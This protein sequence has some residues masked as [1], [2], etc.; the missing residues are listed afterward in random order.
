MSK[1]RSFVVDVN[2]LDRLSENVKIV[3]RL[4]V[5]IPLVFVG[6]MCNLLIVVVLGRDK[7]INKT[8]RFLLQM[9]AL[10]DITYYVLYPVENFLATGLINYSG[11]MSVV[12]SLIHGSQSIASWMAVLVTYQRYVAVSR[13]LHARQYITTS[14]VRIAVVVIWIG[15]LIICTPLYYV[16]YYG[17][18]F[19]YLSNI[20]Q[21]IT[22]YLLPISLTVFLNI[23]LIV[24]IRRSRTFVGQQL[25]SGAAGGNIDSHSASSNRVTVT[26]IVILI[27]Y[28]VCQ[29]PTAT[30][31]VLFTIVDLILDWSC[32]HPRSL[33]HLSI[34]YDIS[35]CLIVV[36]SL[37]DCV[38]YCMIGKRFRQILLRELLC[39]RDNGK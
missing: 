32:D 14:R 1:L 21:V 18:V 33:Y 20:I 23:R 15:S 29:L 16:S 17:F 38:T 22:L 26:L 35:H 30:V 4:Y 39:R 8:T 10:A 28:L 3:R 2:E 34:A 5:E 25:V 19:N 13:P 7:T 11:T 37:A 6:F 31:S 12:L 24:I 36:N 9:L 27:V